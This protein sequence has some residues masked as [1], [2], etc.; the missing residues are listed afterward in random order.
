[1]LIFYVFKIMEN[2]TIF[3]I[4][5]FATKMKHI[6]NRIRALIGRRHREIHVVSGA[7]PSVTCPVDPVPPSG[8]LGRSPDPGAVCPVART[9]RERHGGQGTGADAAKSLPVA[10]LH[11]AVLAGGQSRAADGPAGEVV[12]RGHVV[13]AVLAAQAA[14]QRGHGRPN[15]PAGLR[16][17]VVSFEIYFVD[18]LQI[19][20]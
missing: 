3:E 9:A 8:G 4:S 20:F 2:S 13:R 19:W 14:L 6:I 16:G 12:R 18:D 17:L 1:M 5:L 15:V 7:Q 11:H 10:A